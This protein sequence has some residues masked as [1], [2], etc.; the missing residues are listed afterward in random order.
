MTRT[1]IALEMNKDVQDH[2]ANVIRQ[3]ARVL[4]N[5]RWVD[6]LG[7]HITLAFL[8]ALDDE[9]LQA[10]M[11]ATQGAAQHA[12]AFS[13]RL[14]RLGVFGSVQRPSVLWMGIEEPSGALQTAHHLLQQEL[15]LRDFPADSRS[16]SPHLTLA[17]FKKP[18][19][20]SEQQQLQ[21]ILKGTSFVARQTYAVSALCVMKSELSR[22]GAH[23]TCLQAYSLQ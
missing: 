19:T 5:A 10:A 17:R 15:T 21:T 11:Q 23:Y 18:L 12:H 20:A 2:L 22:S 1:F 14:A 3:V 9:R 6:P 16:F 4:P 7:I 8:G 13:Y